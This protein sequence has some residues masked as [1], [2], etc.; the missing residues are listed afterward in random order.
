[1]QDIMNWIQRIHL[2]TMKLKPMEINHMKNLKVTQ[3]IHIKR[4]RTNDNT[5]FN[6]TKVKVYMSLLLPIIPIILILIIYKNFYM[7]YVDK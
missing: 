5:F 6:A 1:M 4:I 3:T 2:I 7:I